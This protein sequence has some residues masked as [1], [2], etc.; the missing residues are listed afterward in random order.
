M[1]NEFVIDELSSCKFRSFV[2]CDGLNELFESF[3]EFVFVVDNDANILQ[4][5][6]VSINGLGYTEQEILSMKSF[7]LH[8]SE[9]REQVVEKIMQIFEGKK[10]TCEY[11]L[12][13]KDGSLIPVSTRIVVSRFKHKGKQ[14]MYAFC[15][16][17][18]NIKSYENKIEKIFNS[19]SYSMSISDIETGTFIDINEKFEKILQYNRKELIGKKSVELGILEKSER[20]QM[21]MELKTAGAIKSR[22]MKYRTKYGDLRYGE[23]SG[24]I[25]N[26]NGLDYLMLYFID[27]TDKKDTIKNYVSLLNAIPD[28]M[29][30]IRADGL[31]M[32]VK[33]GL[34]TQSYE[35]GSKNFIG[36]NIQDL[37]FNPDV[38][39]E[40]KYCI[41]Q[42]INTNTPFEYRYSFKIRSGTKHYYTRSIKSS[43]DEIIVIVRDITDGV[44]TENNLIR[45][46]EKAEESDKMKLDFLANM[47]HDLRTPMNAIIGF[48][49]LLK[50]NNISKSDKN[51][52]LN[53]IINNGKFLMALIDDIIDISKIDSHSL[54]IENKDFELNKL[55]DELRSSYQKSAKDK[56]IDLILDIN[57]NKSVVV[58]SDK[59]RL[60][61]ILMNLI[62]N[63]TKFTKEGYVQFGYKILNNYMLEIY[64]IDTGIGIPKED[65]K[66]IFEKFK[67]L[68]K[69][70]HKFKG[71]GL[72]LSIS[73][74]IVQLLGFKDIKLNSEL[75]RGS[76]FY[77][78]V[79]YTLKNV[80]DEDITMDKKSEN[81]SKLNNK[82]I[83]VVEDDK[84]SRYIMK[85]ILN[86]FKVNVLECGDGNNVMDIIKNN[87]INLVL[88]DVGL[89]NKN[90]YELTSEIK[91]YNPKIPVIIETAL[92]MPEE[93]STAYESGCD[94]Y[95]TK[96]FNEKEFISKINRLL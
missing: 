34:E 11:P 1:E 35:F 13:K 59:Y 56:N 89:P 23:F 76:K 67:Q 47:S 19:N 45:E 20:E 31:I 50:A 32:D 60:R 15:R 93:K 90:G 51:D 84:D 86:K 33:P 7:E 49:D 4:T 68:S 95:I 30:R 38:I 28:L 18:S 81:Y 70:G 69:S 40:M 80:D 57:I 73:K 44:E 87:T 12:L 63:A 96:P 79:P 52:Y 83:L 74:S 27:I 29:V 88:M 9:D 78:Y 91:K 75:G 5:N 62:S 65:H 17:L 16:D 21:I 53:T 26:I 10:V 94:D 8:L 82:T 36:Q 48:S 77:F 43:E 58:N 66:I 22:E 25:L 92:A 37:P 71:A 2:N 6:A 42:V 46:K 64:V 72:G 3:E 85:V 39:R 41:D 54:K 55:F 14:V 61:Q 24:D